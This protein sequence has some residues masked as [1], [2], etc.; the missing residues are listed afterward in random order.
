MLLVGI[1]QSFLY[2]NMAFSPD[3]SQI[4]TGTY[5]SE[6]S[7][8]DLL[9]FPWASLATTPCASGVVLLANVEESSSF[10]MGANDPSWGPTDL[11]AYGAGSDVYLIP[12]GGG[13]PRNL[14]TGL[15]GDAGIVTASDPVW[16][17]PCTPVP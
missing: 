2:P 7:P 1:L 4:V 10:N 9:V 5:C 13:S 15:T 17:P 14:T 3:Y 12:A 16:A 6:E 11:I 8:L